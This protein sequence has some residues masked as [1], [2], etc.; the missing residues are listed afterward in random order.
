MAKLFISAIAIAALALID[1]C[2][3]SSNSEHNQTRSSVGTSSSSGLP[4]SPTNDN[5]TIAP[6]DLPAAIRPAMHSATSFR[7]F[8]SMTKDGKEQEVDVR[9]GSHKA[10]W[11]I[12]E[13]DKTMEV[14]KP[15]GD[16]AY[17]KANDSMW[18]KL[19]GDS[20]GL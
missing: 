7:V 9:I 12:T 18:R 8:G 5:S 11:S 14:I 20:V 15:G 19:G 4:T 17:M 16:W 10:R 13:D 2:G 1:A 6:A 3:P